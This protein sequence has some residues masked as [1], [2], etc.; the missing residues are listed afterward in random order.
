MPSL[1]DMIH[2]NVGGRNFT[3]SRTT[4]LS[5]P[6]SSSSWHP[7][8]FFQALLS[9]TWSS[10]TPDGL[11]PQSPFFI[12]RDPD[13]FSIV[14]HYLRTGKL[15]IPPHAFIDPASIADEAD[16]YNLPHL[17]SLALAL[18]SSTHS[19][20]IGYEEEL[21]IGLLEREKGE[22]R[23][24]LRHPMVEGQTL[25]TKDDTGGGGRRK[26]WVFDDF[27]FGQ[28]FE[29][30]PL[31]DRYFDENGTLPLSHQ[32]KKKIGPRAAS[33]VL[34]TTPY[35]HFH[36][37]TTL[38]GY[39]WVVSS[40]VWYR[41]ADMRLGERMNGRHDDLQIMIMRRIGRSED[42]EWRF[43]GEK[44]M[45]VGMTGVGGGNFVGDEGEKESEKGEEEGQGYGDEELGE[46]VMSV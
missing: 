1:N 46:L 4:L 7:S 35:P 38:S 42:E 6:S 2:L 17:A 45:G 33:T 24:F 44:G 31:L 14:L 9:P 15:R 11:T 20:D 36:G 21:W 28:M 13:T 40:P 12:D 10:S 41:C 26:C 29:L 22:Y 32:P 39:R 34:F 25:V 8:T 18:S 16:F 30:G 19:P 5:S 3:T 43:A 23:W 27:H 37:S